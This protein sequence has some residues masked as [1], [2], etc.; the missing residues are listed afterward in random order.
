MWCIV[1]SR[2]YLISHLVI[3]IMAETECQ[4]IQLYQN[5]PFL[6]FVS[7]YSK[8]KFVP[9]C[10]VEQYRGAEVYVSGW[11]YALATLPLRNECLEPF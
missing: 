2:N 3:Q 11:P 8:G 7:M 10:A 9:I 1:R 4:Y 5:D 6:L